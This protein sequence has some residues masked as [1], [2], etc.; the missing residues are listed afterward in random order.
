[1]RAAQAS[2][3]PMAELEHGIGGLAELVH[4]LQENRIKLWVPE[5]LTQFF[6]KL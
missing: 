5:N 3:E 1:M 6:Q 4:S 2:D